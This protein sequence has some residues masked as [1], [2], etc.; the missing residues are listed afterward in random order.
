M[1]S[2]THAASC[3]WQFEARRLPDPSLYRQPKGVPA[4]AAAAPA[5]GDDGD[6]F[7]LEKAA[8]KAPLKRTTSSHAPSKSKLA[9]PSTSP[10]A[11]RRRSFSAFFRQQLTKF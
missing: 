2:T 7:E 4:P 6:K 11:P 1:N 3:Q 8:P 10:Q 9:D 5:V